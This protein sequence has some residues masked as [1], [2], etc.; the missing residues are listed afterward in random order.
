MELLDAFR[1][2]ILALPALAKFAVAIA[3]I[4]GVPPPVASG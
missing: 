3:V 2:Q 1:S 4:V